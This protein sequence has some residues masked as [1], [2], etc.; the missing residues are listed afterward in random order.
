MPPPPSNRDL[1]PFDLETGVRV[2]SKVE[3]LPS[4]FGHARPLRSRIILYVRDGRTD[5]RTD[6]RTRSPYMSHTGSVSNQQNVG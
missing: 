1:C 3:N 5:R 4:K 6:G 2:S